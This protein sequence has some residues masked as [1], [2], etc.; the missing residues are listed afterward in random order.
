MTAFLMSL[1]KRKVEVKKDLPTSHENLTLIA[2][3]VSEGRLN[4]GKSKD[5]GT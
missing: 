2:A 3:H 4:R 1:F 5:F